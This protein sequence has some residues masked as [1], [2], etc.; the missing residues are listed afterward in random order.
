[1]H[2]IKKAYLSKSN[3]V[4][5]P[6]DIVLF[7]ESK[8]KGISEIGV[9]EEFHKDLTYEEIIS[10]VGKRSVYS[11][12]ELK[13]YNGKN[14][15]LLFIHSKKINKITKKEL[16]DSNIIKAHPQSAQRLDEKNYVKLK[17]LMEE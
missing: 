10:R 7:Y 6:R 3:A 2:T 17:K 14:R 8:N 1:M 9:V 16:I 12:D 13:D 5:K 11:Q 15:V 4:L